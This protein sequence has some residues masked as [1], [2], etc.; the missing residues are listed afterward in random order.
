MLTF[1]SKCKNKQLSNS[2][3]MSQLCSDAMSRLSSDIA[4]PAG[5]WKAANITDISNTKPLDGIGEMNQWNK[6][7]ESLLDQLGSKESYSVEN[8]LEF[9]LSLTKMESENFVT[10]L[11]RVEWVIENVLSS[12]SSDNEKWTRLIFLLGLNKVD[13]KLAL[14]RVEGKSLV[15]LAD[16]VESL[17]FKD[18]PETWS[19][20]ES[21]MTEECGQEI[22]GFETTI[23]PD[24][25][26]DNVIFQAETFDDQ[27]DF[28]SEDEPILKRRKTSSMALKECSVDLERIDNENTTT[29]QNPTNGCA[30]E[31]KYKKDTEKPSEAKVMTHEKHAL[32]SGLNRHERTHTEEKRFVCLICGKAFQTKHKLKRHE[33]RHT[34]EKPFACTKCDEA[35]K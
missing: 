33:R 30:L 26:D 7:K 9:M 11:N 15:D 10:Y 2:K 14:E 28:S 17:E 8:Q 3:D 29:E 19:F 31:I 35:Y 32:K 16:L 1:D 12:P 18:E 5:A 21:E 25:M 4:T 24:W 20:D 6:M 34:G 13:Q 23:N 22:R 27:C